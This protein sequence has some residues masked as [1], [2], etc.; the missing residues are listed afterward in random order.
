MADLAADQLH[1]AADTLVTRGQLL[2][3]VDKQESD[4]EFDG[5]VLRLAED[6]ALLSARA[7]CISFVLSASTDPKCSTPR[8]MPSGPSSRSSPISACL[9]GQGLYSTR[10]RTAAISWCLP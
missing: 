2:T 4:H 9:A 10:R 1:A 3:L 6:L 7:V 8:H 5:R